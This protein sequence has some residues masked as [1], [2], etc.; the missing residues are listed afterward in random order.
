MV[1]SDTYPHEVNQDFL[2][3]LLDTYH[4]DGAFS[5]EEMKTRVS[6]PKMPDSRRLLLHFLP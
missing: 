4:C 5:P 6:R 1:K 3:P 2:D